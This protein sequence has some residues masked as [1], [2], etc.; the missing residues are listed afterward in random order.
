MLPLLS[1]L[2]VCRQMRRMAETRAVP[3]IM[4]TARGEEHDKVRGLEVGADDYVTKPFSVAELLARIK[5]IFRR[6]H[7]SEEA[8]PA[9]IP[10]QSIRRVGDLLQ[11]P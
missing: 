7:R 8:A 3:I 11:F 5:A 10:L 9:T 6:L 4:L 1:G 2:E